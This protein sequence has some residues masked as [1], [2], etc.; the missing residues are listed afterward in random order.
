MYF[1]RLKYILF[2]INDLF[3]LCKVEKVLNEY[4]AEI[5]NDK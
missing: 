3:F 4:E 5:K 2:K 1:K